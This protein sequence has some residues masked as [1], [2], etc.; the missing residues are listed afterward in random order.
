MQVC[1]ET[2]TDHRGH[3]APC[4]LHLD[5]RTIEITEI[6]DRWYGEDYCYFKVKTATGDTYILRFDE[7]TAE[8]GLTMFQSAQPH[9]VPREFLTNKRPARALTM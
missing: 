9:V 7:D 5:V 2:Y 4:R 8:W 1:V 6:V 3:E